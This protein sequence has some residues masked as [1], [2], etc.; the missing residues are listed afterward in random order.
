MT[1]EVT[2][3]RI[4]SMKTSFAYNGQLWF[5]IYEDEEKEGEMWYKCTNGR[6]SDLF[7]HSEIIKGIDEYKLS[8]K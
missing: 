6:N 3:T 4:E 2:D 5:V 7:S 1:N 8:K